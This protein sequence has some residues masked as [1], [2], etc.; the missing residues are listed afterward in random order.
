MIKNKDLIVAKIP[1]MVEKT[2]IYSINKKF[3][4]IKK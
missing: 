2:L 3:K 1:L 4:N